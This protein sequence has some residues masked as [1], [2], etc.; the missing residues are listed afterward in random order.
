MEDLVSAA[1]NKPVPSF[2][3]LMI[4]CATE[5]LKKL[6]FSLHNAHLPMSQGN[7]CTIQDPFHH[8]RYSRQIQQLGKRCLRHVTY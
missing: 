4:F 1:V 8:H 7:H 6:W 3:F 5:E 2:L